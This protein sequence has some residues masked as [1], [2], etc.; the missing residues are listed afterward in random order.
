MT[1]G[2][3]AGGDASVPRDPEKN[4]PEGGDPEETGPE[5]H[6][7][8]AQRP[9]ASGVE[10]AGSDGSDA[11]G[12]GSDAADT[13]RE[14]LDADWA[15]S[16]ASDADDGAGEQPAPGGTSGWYRASRWLYPLVVLLALGVGFGLGRRSVA[17]RVI[18]SGAMSGLE[19]RSFQGPADA[20]VTI[21][22]Y[23]DYDC[24]F[25]KRYHAEIYPTLLQEYSGKVRY[26][27]RHFPLQQLHPRAPN[28]ARAAVCAEAQDRFWSYH[29]LLFFRGNAPD[30]AG[31]VAYA[32]ELGLDE[33]Q[34][35]VCMDD[36]E[37][38]SA[39]MADLQR[40]AAYGVRGTPAFFINGRV[41]FG[42]QRMEVFRQVMDAAL[43]E[44]GA[45]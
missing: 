44:A 43:E 17:E 1:G 32:D 8:E 31:L 14:A 11:H 26:F 2:T 27:V 3:G 38:A 20:P 19:D 4:E 23:T 5:A 13:D 45:L 10:L 12:A 7:A 37:T 16:E 15:S 42:A 39:V 21:V 28:A 9:G 6:E 41:V 33:E 34:F 40:G 18:F 30:D 36:S 35:S 25:C 22:E 29:E 24:P